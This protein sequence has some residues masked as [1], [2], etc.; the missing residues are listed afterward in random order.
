MIAASARDR[1]HDLEARLR[2]FVAR[3]VR[4][5]PDI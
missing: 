2:P 3:R 4:A 1:W 5:E